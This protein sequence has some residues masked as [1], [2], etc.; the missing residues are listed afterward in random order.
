MQNLK[1]IDIEEICVIDDDTMALFL[2]EKILEYEIPKVPVKVFGNVDDSLAYLSKN[3]QTKRLIFV[4]LN[5]PM[6]DG[7]FFLESYHGNK[8]T[9]L[10]FILSSSDNIL[11]KNKAKTFSHVAD[12]L[13]KPISI[14]QIIG[15]LNRY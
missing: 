15:L 12:Y 10:I 5:M 3:K 4:D 1:I 2:A 11:D 7:W 13:E 9:D 14:E 6:K 8:A